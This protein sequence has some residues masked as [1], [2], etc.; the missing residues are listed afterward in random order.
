[1]TTLDRLRSWFSIAIIALIWINTALIV[2]RSFFTSMASP[3][4][5]IAGGLAIAG[6]A[7][8]SWAL[9]RTGSATRIV[10]SLALAA[11]TALLVYGFAGSPLQIDVHMYFFAMLAICAGWIDWRA[12]VA[13]AALTAVHHVLLFAAIPWAVFPGESTFVRVILHAIVVVVE[14]GAL[15]AITAQLRKSFE[16]VEI[17]IADANAARDEARALAQSQTEISQSAQSRNEQMASANETFR[18][19]VAQSLS[20]MENE[21]SRVKEIGRHMAEMAGKA[22]ENALNVASASTES[23]INA[24]NVATAADRMSSSIDDINRN[25][26][27]TMTTIHTATDTI[28][29]AS[30]KVAVL[31]ED[32]TRINEVV[33]IIQSIAE[34]TNLLALNA[35]IEAARAGESG[36]GFAVVAGEVKNLAEQTSKATEEIGARIAAIT[37]STTETVNGINSAVSTMGEVSEHTAAVAE[38]MKSQ[39]GLTGE[40]AHNIREAAAGTELVAKSSTEASDHAQQGASAS[41]DMLKMIDATASAATTLEHDIDLFLKKIAAA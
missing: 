5:L 31:A 27:R 24:Q 18:D 41:A 7:T 23:S 38:A 14:L 6:A 39:H 10:T 40:I 22:S 29:S 2:V 25:L 20:A 32:A 4:V 30:E 34:Q 15:V 3:S 21:L 17:V 11:Q 33:S 36:R 13:F 26:S 12:T 1:M 19:T 8:V 35:T 9:N 37:S 28:R 16:Q